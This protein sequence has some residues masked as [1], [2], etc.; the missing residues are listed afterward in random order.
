MFQEVVS[1]G[2]DQ[3]HSGKLQSM[4]GFVVNSVISEL[5]TL[6]DLFIL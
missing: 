2:D 4:Q 1:P 5:G 3:R 6:V